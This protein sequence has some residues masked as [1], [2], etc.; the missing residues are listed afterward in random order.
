MISRDI[1][2]SHPISHLKKEISKTNIKGYSKMKKNEIIELMMKTPKRFSHI[3]KYEKKKAEPKKAEKKAEK[4]EPKK[5]DMDISAFFAGG[6]SKKKKEKPKKEPKKKEPKKAEKP[7]AK[8]AGT[9]KPK[10]VNIQNMDFVFI[11]TS[12]SDSLIWVDDKYIMRK[13][14]QLYDEARPILGY[15]TN[16]KEW[17]STNK[18]NLKISPP[19]VKAGETIYNDK[20]KPF[21]INDR[22]TEYLNEREREARDEALAEEATQKRLGL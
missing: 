18:Y 20:Y 8:A 12:F 10:K 2:N 14:D 21:E 22:K 11:E 15:Y 13:G 16:K 4:K 5:A 19:V 1:L 7:K 6:A 3:E 17:N 9:K